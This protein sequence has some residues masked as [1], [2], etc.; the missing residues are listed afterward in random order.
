M[1][2][3]WIINLIPRKAAAQMGIRSSN[4]EGWVAGAL[5]ALKEYG[6]EDMTLGLAF[7]V[8]SEDPMHGKIDGIYYFGFSEDSSHPE[9]YDPALEASL[10]LILEEFRPDVI[11]I[12]GT[13][14]PHCLACLKVSEWRD[15]VVIHL[16]GIMRKCA[17]VYLADLPSD[18]TE[19][20]TFRDVLRSDSL[21]KQKEK[22]ESRA[23]N[24]EE[25]IKLVKHVCGR[26]AFDK[27]FVSGLN[28]ECNYY[29]LNE[30]LR[31][32]FYGK[33]WNKEKRGRNIVMTQGNI[34]LKGAHV[35][36]KAMPLILKR[37]PD[38]T[39]TI[40][41]DNILKGS[42]PVA[43]M[44]R[45]GYGRYLHKLAKDPAIRDCVEFTGSL[46][47]E[48][49]LELYL[50]SDV[51]VLPSFVENSPNSLGEAMLLGLPC[52][53]CETGGIPSMA[54]KDEEALLVPPGDEKAL[55]EAVIK[56]FENEEFAANLAMAGRKRAML[57]FDRQAN[58][59][60]LMWIY[61]QICGK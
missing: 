17:D 6:S 8:K 55:A 7:P 5:D 18:I 30:T 23:A 61:D 2:V 3:L 10:G 60:M 50:D 41:G 25:S 35:M 54:K 11:E 22:Y 34:P 13:E 15:R 36:L 47:A 9:K 44:K 14:F 38:A 20:A 42:G 39:L 58:I 48:D 49:L 43:A 12:F 4:K 33:A 51:F 56:I 52:V 45:C 27:E 37:F 46:R 59:K 40:A 21:K 57:T 19:R 28:P 31:S 29:S 26:T 1:K 53:A 32:C 16:Q 24:E